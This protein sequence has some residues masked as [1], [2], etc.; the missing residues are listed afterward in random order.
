M[1]LER[2]KKKPG[3]THKM[4]INKN[5][6]CLVWKV[7]TLFSRIFYI[8]RTGNFNK[9]KKVYLKLNFLSKLW[10]TNKNFKISA[11]KLELTTK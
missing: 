4:S 9:K 3:V 2:K 1:G 7:T 6:N 11:L 5:T 10:S 8:I